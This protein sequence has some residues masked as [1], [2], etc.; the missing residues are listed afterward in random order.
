MK[1]L[2]TVQQLYAAF[3]R[4]DIPAILNHL[5]EDVAWEYTPS[6][7]QVPW[8]QLRHGLDEVPKFFE[9]L[10]AMEIHTFQPKTFLENE[11]GQIIVVLIDVEMTVKA[12]GKKIVEEDEVNIWHFN[13]DGQVI[14]FTHKADTHQHWIAYKSEVSEAADLASAKN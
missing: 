11:N 5:A 1:N 2:E 9:S 7:A 8:L 13:K 3:G 12:T 4:G 6:S 14:K 10:G